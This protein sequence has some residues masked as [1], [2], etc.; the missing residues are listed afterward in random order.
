[1]STAGTLNAYNNGVCCTV[2]ATGLNL[3]TALASGSNVALGTLPSGYRPPVTAYVVV[4]T[5]SATYAGGLEVVIGTD[6]AMTLY[7]ASGSS[8]ATTFNLN[9]T[10]TWAI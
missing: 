10:V 7:N 4:A 8:I 6:G 5:S 3:N 9:F 1:M 2:C